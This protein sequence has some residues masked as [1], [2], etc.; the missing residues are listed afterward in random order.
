MNFKLSREIYSGVWMIDPFS[1][2]TLTKMLEDQRSG[3]TFDKDSEKCNQFGY[4][5][6]KNSFVYGANQIESMENVPRETI[7]VYNLDSVI[8]KYG[9]YSHYGTVEIANQFKKMEANENIIGHIFNIESGGGSSNAIKYLREVTNSSVRNKPLVT[10]AEDIMASAAMYLASDSDYIFVKS[11]DALVGSI[12]TMVEFDGY[13]ANSEDTTGKRHIRLY[14]SQSVNK[15]KEYEDAINDFNF[16]IIQKEILE[17]HAAEFIVDMENNRPNITEEQKTGKIY[18]AGDTVGTLIDAIGSFEDAIAKVN[19]LV[20]I[21]NENNIN[22]N[23]VNMDATQLQAEYPDLVTQFVEQGVSQ[24]RARLVKANETVLKYADKAPN[25]T[26][27]QLATCQGS[28]PEF[29]DS[30][31]EEVLSKDFT[32]NAE[33][34][35]KDIN[36]TQTVAS[37]KSKE[38]TEEEK[39]D[40]EDAA[41][42]KSVGLG[43]ETK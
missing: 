15:N 5:D 36:A 34:S 14:A 35:T 38:K 28:T 8:T 42:L 39:I 24:E 22:Q 23:K 11:K 16:E 7:A 18:R 26:L 41:I 4:L 13:K 37:S 25:A 30:V 31:A 12:G 40:A 17:P 2:Q 29:L 6:T 1:L 21:E 10:Y 19:E 43:K 27:A 33:D 3:I 20:N 32:K 9:G